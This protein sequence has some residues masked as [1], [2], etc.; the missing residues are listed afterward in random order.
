MGIVKSW[1][2][3]LKKE[4]TTK[5]EERRAKICDSC[6]HKTYS[7]YLDFID[8]EVKEVKGFY[9]G[10]CFCP[11]VAKIKEGNHCVKWD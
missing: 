11:L 4:S 5:E 7:K 6:N 8:N 1:V 9:C 10:N 3:V 2:S